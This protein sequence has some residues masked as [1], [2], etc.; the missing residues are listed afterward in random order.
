MSLANRLALLFAACTAAVALLAGALFSRASEMHFIELDQQLLDSKLLEQASIS[1]VGFHS[2]DMRVLKAPQLFS[3]RAGL[4][5]EVEKI[6]KHLATLG[7]TRL[8]RVYD[9]RSEDG[10]HDLDDTDDVP[11]LGAALVQQGRRE[12]QRHPHPRRRAE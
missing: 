12:Q 5:E 1:L 10:E 3:T 6:A 9:E 2:T 11:S 4:P 8:A 7:L